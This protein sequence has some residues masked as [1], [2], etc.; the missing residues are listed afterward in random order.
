MDEVARKKGARYW[1]DKTPEHTLLADEIA[2]SYPDAKF[3]AIVRDAREVLR[4]SFGDYRNSGWRRR[5]ALARRTFN[6]VHHTKEIGRFAG[7]SGRVRVVR[8]E[9]LQGRPEETLRDLAAF[10]DLEFE[11]GL[12]EPHYPPNTT[13]RAGG[14]AALRTWAC[15][16]R[17]TN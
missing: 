8:F 10:L 17:S 9:A 4:S 12:L 5:L 13:F 2:L 1:L 15:W 16:P 14:R 3:V 6:L 7:R 11:P